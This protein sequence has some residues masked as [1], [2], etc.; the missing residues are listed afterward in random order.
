MFYYQMLL[1][2]CEIVEKVDFPEVRFLSKILF[3]KNT[4]RPRILVFYRHSGKSLGARSTL[5]VS[6]EISR[7]YL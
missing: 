7:R 4:E 2:F 6:V 3:Q 1:V 5:A